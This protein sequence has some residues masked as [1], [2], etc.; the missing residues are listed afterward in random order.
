M[1]KVMRPAKGKAAGGKCTIG[2]RSGASK[3]RGQFGRPSKGR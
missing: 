2:N 1:P 3:M